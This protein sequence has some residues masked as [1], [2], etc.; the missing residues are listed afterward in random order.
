MQSEYKAGP[1][2]KKPRQ[3][4]EVAFSGFVL[5]FGGVRKLYSYGK[6]MWPTG[7]PEYDSGILDVRDRECPTNYTAPLI[8]LAPIFEGR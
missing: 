8:R 5:K 1:G 7:E 2:R 3:K 4:I 6:L